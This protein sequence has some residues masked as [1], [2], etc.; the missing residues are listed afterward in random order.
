MIGCGYRY[1][2]LQFADSGQQDIAVYG[3][4]WSKFFEYFYDTAGIA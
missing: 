1:N 4:D 2:I 3:I